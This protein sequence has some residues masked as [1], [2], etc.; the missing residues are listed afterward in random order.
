MTTAR[1]L[2]IASLL[3]FGALFFWFIV[4][5]GPEIAEG[6]IVPESFIPMYFLTPIIIILL[7]LNYILWSLYESKKASLT[8]V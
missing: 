3:L 5:I 6:K 7:T 4:V 1:G 2:I 8:Y